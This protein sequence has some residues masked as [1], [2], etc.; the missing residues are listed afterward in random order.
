MQ[1][2]CPAYR[3]NYVD[4]DPTYRDAWGNPL[5]RVTFDFTDNERKMVKYVA[6]KALTRII[7]QMNPSIQQVI[8][9]ITSFNSVP[10]H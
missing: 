7:A 3:Q 6:E 1:G 9:T 4:L 10:Y 5:L 2:E 8:D